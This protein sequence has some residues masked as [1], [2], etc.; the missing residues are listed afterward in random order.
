MVLVHTKKAANMQR[1]MLYL[2]ASITLLLTIMAKNYAPTSRDV[3]DAIVSPET[4][5]DLSAFIE[6]NKRLITKEEV[7]DCECGC[8]KSPMP[9]CQ[10]R[11][12][13]EDVKMSSKINYSL[14]R[15][16]RDI[17]NYMQLVLMKN[18]Q[19]ALTQCLQE[20]E[21]KGVTS[22]GGYCLAKGK[23]GGSMTLPFPDRSIQLSSGHYPTSKKFLR[24]LL[25]FIKKEEMTSLSD[26]GAGQGQYGAD[27][28]R[29]IPD[30][31][32]Y[33]GYDGAGDVEIFTQSFLHYFDLTI[34]LQL[35]MSDWVMSFEV[36]EHIPPHQEGMVIRNL[37]AHNCKGIILSWSQAGHDGHHH[38]NLHNNEYLVE[39][40]MELGY[41]VDKKATELLTSGIP[42]MWSF[43]RNSIVL[44]RKVPICI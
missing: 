1:R 34:P 16:P 24:N 10:R 18:Q 28:S 17:S 14:Q 40:F 21:E 11:Y 29:S 15:T 32:I 23:L 36:G 9:E 4:L 19:E 8:P 42:N 30:T 20:V 31:L 2:V 12:S 22:T 41:E 44:R 43:L 38:V 25:D 27:I 13:L 5:L 39:L 7:K 26:F 37:H 3:L 33:R 35:P 6:I